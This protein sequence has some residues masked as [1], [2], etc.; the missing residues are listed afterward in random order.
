MADGSTGSGGPVLKFD[1]VWLVLKRPRPNFDPPSFLAPG[2][3]LIEGHGAKFGPSDATLSW[4]FDRTP[5]KHLTMDRIV[6]VRRKRYGWGVVPR[7]VEIT[8]ETTGRAEVAYFNDGGWKGWRPMVTGSNRRMV[9][10]I[11]Q[12]QGVA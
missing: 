7:L 1:P 10:A 8:Y 9:N 11:R 3:L 2:E 6:G 12:Y 5:D 4:P